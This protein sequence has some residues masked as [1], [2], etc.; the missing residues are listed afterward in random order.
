MNNNF[1]RGLYKKMSLLGT[2]GLIAVVTAIFGHGCGDIGKIDGSGSQAM[3]M[4]S[5]EEFDLIPGA[6]TVGTVYA[7]QVLDNMLACTGLTAESP[8]TREEYQNRIGSLSE[9]GYATHVTPPMAMALVALAGEVCNDLI[10][11][12]SRL[13][14]TQRNIFPSFN[15]AAGSVADADVRDASARMSLA[16]WQRNQDSEEAQIVLDTLRTVRAANSAE[17]VRKTAL[18]LCTGM[19]ASLEAIEI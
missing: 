3:Y 10:E 12:E 5:D 16:C 6:R 15:F 8:R 11:I 9:F 1:L 13:D 14:W 7:K 19:L 4:E 18:S 17:A 2:L